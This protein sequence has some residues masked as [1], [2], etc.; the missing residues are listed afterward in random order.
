[1]K[2]KDYLKT[3]YWRGFRAS[4]L[5]R[6]RY[7]QK[8]G[9]LRTNK[10]IFN[11]HHIN[12]KNLFNEKDEDIIVLC[13]DCHKKTHNT[14][15]WK[16]KYRNGEDLAFVRC[17]NP[18]DKIYNMSDVIMPCNRCG[19]E[20]AVFYKRY[21][22]DTLHLFMACPYSKPRCKGIKFIPNLN[23]PIK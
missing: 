2:Y 7:C 14:K 11:I 5:S 6:R 1:M 20:H 22:N 17:R 23:I 10:T 16:Q 4:V 19:K 12:Y 15:K 18:K 3:K 9:I 13:Q 21:K 8:C